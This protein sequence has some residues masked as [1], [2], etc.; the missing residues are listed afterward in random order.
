MFRIL[1]K[2]SKNKIK[3]R[4]IKNYE[5][6]FTYFRH[7]SSSVKILNHRRWKLP[8]EK[9]K[10]RYVGQLLASF[11]FFIAKFRSQVFND[12]IRVTHLEFA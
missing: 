12:S 6:R 7:L 10:I 4:K 11:F 3:I 8:V 5:R 9:K 2:N 1:F